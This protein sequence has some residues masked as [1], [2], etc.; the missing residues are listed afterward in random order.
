[1]KVN[2]GRGESVGMKGYFHSNQWLFLLVLISSS[3]CLIASFILSK[4][5][6]L[7]ASSPGAALNCDINEVVSCSKVAEA[8]QANLFG[9]PNAFLGMMTEPVVVT[10]AVAGLAHMK[11]PRWFMFTAQVVY[12]LAFIFAWWLFFQSA[13]V[14]YSLCPYCLIITI[15]T[16]ITF[17]TLLHYNIRENNL[18]MPAKLQQLLETL[19]RLRMTELAGAF[20]VGLVLVIIFAL[21]GLRIFGL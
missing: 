3:L 5:A 16:S 12:L 1:M 15:F 8:W 20:F 13:F 11:F 4:D 7:L 17:F 19:T 9:F 2:V 18:F 10:I 21:Y 14:I 6:L